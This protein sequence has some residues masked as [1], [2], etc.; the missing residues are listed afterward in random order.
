[1][2][3]HLSRWENEGWVGVKDRDILWCLAAE[4][5]I[6]TGQTLFIVDEHGEM[7]ELKRA[8]AR[9]DEACNASQPGTI[10]V[11]IPDGYELPGVS[12]WP[13][14]ASG[15]C[16]APSGNERT[17]RGRRGSRQRNAWQTSRLTCSTTMTGAV[18]PEDIW[19]SA[20]TKDIV[21][22]ARNFI[23]RMMHDSFRLGRKWEDIPHCEN[24][25]VCELC[26]TQ[27]TI[28]HILLECN[29]PGQEQVWAEAKAL[30]A[31]TGLP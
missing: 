18:N 10:A 23:W 16:T 19:L 12:S 13:I 15:L 9:A 27:E 8:N 2:N 25:G 26:G 5:R 17:L 3:K 30:W 14:P 31:K 21:S 29:H 11:P 28:Q 22:S 6:R 20:H 1:M 24:F 7:Q 4:L